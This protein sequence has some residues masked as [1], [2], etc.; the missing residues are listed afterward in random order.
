MIYF[1][2]VRF[3]LQGALVGTA[4][5]L[6]SQALRMTDAASVLFAFVCTAI[7][8]LERIDKN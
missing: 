1:S 7:F 3:I 2:D 6:I 5:L 4:S 8:A